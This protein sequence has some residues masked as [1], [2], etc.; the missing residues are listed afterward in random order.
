MAFSHDDYTVAWICALPLEMTAAK[1]ML[2]KL[3]HQLSQPKSDHNA[4]TLGSISGH[5]VVVACLPS[6]VYGTTSAAVVLAHMLLTF[7][8]LRFGLMVGIGGGVP[9]KEA[10]IRLGDVV[11][12]MP[13]ASSGGVIQYDYGKTLRDG[14]FERTGSLNKPPQYLLTAISQMRSKIMGGNTLIEEIASEI[15]QK[16]EKLQEQFSRPDE[17][18]LFQA[19]YDHEGK[20]AD[21]SKCEPDQLVTRTIR[22]GKE[23]VVH[24]GLIA[25]GNQVM[26]SATTRDDVARKLNIL[27]FEMEA[28]GLMDQL[29]CL[30]I[31]GVCD[32]CDSHKH[33]RWQGYAA[34][35]A[36][37]YTRALLG[38]VPLFGS[39]SSDAK[40]PRHWM[41]PFARN[42]RFVG[43]QQEIHYIEN[44]IICATG[45]TKVA[46]HGLGGIGKTQIA[47]ELAYRTR[48]KVPER[49]IFWIP[50]TSYESVQQAYVN[51][52]SALGISDI[53][54]A[55]MKEQVKSHL[56][57][58]R[59]GKWLLIF[60]NADNM[61]M[62]T[63]G[64]ATAPPL[65]NFLP[66]SG[67]G[68]ILFT[69][70]NR[71]L[72][73]KV[74]SPNVLSI[75]DVDQITAMKI[76]EKSLIQEGLLHD[77]YTTTAL[78]EQLGFLPLAISQ[79][80]A[81]MN[82]NKI[83]LSDYLSLL[84]ERETN[85]AE[86]LSEEFEDDGR[87]PE[88]Q[89]P[90]LATWMIS[91]QQIQDL[92]ELAADYLSF[93]A[94]I[95]PRDIP[96]SI[97]PPATSAKKRVDAL[98]LLS[99]YSFIS[100]HACNSS[101]SLHQL[102]H[103]ATRNWMR[104]TEVLVHWVHRATQQLDGIFPDDD[105]NN[106]RLWREYL[107]HAL[108]LI[109][110][111][112]FHDIHYEYVGLSS[113]VGRSLQSDG[114]YNE[115]KVIFFDCL[116]VREKAL[117]PE[118]PD[119]LTSVSNLGSVL[120]QQGKYEEAEAM[121]RRALAGRETIL[122]PEHPD[123]LTSVSHLGSVLEQQS[124]YEEAEAMHRRALAGREIVLGPEHPDTLTSVSLLSSVLER[125]GKYEEA[126]DMHRQAL[127][128][129]KKILGLEHPDTLTSVSHLGFVLKRQGKYEEAEDMHRRA[130][131]GRE[132]VLGPEHPDTLTSVSHLG[133]VLERQGKYGE[134]EAMHRRALAGYETVLGPEHPDTLANFSLL[135]S[136]LKRQ[137]KYEEAEAMHWRDALGSEKV[138]GPE[139]P[140][141]LT[142]V[143]HLGSVLE[144]QGKYE[145]A[146]AIHRRALVGY[147]KA[148]GPEHPDTLASV[149]H[150]GSVLE[151]QGKYE[152]AE[153]IHR[154]A[155]VGYEKALGP[156]HPDT[157]AS[158]SNLGSVLER[159]GK[160]EE[161][162]ALH[163]RDVLGS[164][165]VLGPE[166]PD[167]LTSVSHLGSVLERQGKYEDAEDI[168]R[169][170]LAGYEK[171]LGPK[172]PDTLASVGHLGSVL[173]RQGKYEEAESMHR[174]ALAGRETVLGPEHPDTLTGF[175]HLGFVLEQQGKY[176][177]A[178][179]IYRR[180]LLGY[181][182]ALGSEHPHT[183]TSVSHLGSVL[184]RQGKYE[185]AEAMHRRTLVGYE[186][187]LGPEHP[188]TLACVSHLGSVLE[189]Q[190][191]FEE[192]EAIHRQ[193]LAG[194]EQAL[195]PQNPDTV[196]SIEP[197]TLLADPNK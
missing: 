77:S 4:Y 6:G 78:L 188:D 84:K 124:K 131:A 172:H 125:Q 26:K 127:S 141:T 180:A 21:C 197:T 171:A 74:A 129:R 60:D 194:Y 71:K 99:A 7:P 11:I 110:S 94:C 175:T 109:N 108:Y 196:T 47:L 136:V 42:T 154:R 132:I 52:A 153:A 95:N 195:E 167:T 107:P 53:E 37:T 117:G 159:Q 1:M 144:R 49:S 187:V 121:H 87:Y 104:R 112:E 157:L 128:D 86:L 152:E 25:S 75:P 23:P 191:K 193:A 105:H 123:I 59:A 28:A 19:R 126:E 33:K 63:K 2:D 76:L 186:T 58:D 29:P 16:H 88:T 181:G 56:S 120:E 17:D 179:A 140:D 97:L 65:K 22:E 39:Q 173:E 55:K 34:L 143:S 79:A 145:E 8:S 155:L 40:E 162:E 89:N 166:H 182:K 189:R 119:T 164:E 163:W 168:H 184:E 93:I 170:A 38:V 158:V 176:K 62:W 160:Y 146:E 31:R 10:D 150:L 118:D 9:S 80:S 14:C 133:S 139:H 96:Q 70:R 161:A 190:G 3:H 156:E 151:R 30:V 61:E 18:W 169:R 100:E 32:Y 185:E 81:Y 148:L 57:Q 101:F 130:L 48:E 174:Q 138:L 135:G 35:T 13:T 102:V 46:I 92:D 45:P 116:K 114:R 91:F 122:G 27:C 50:C 165:K 54:P 64:S 177:V 137:G 83:V 192:A 147:E 43:R 178:E 36:A 73:V 72:A 66:R 115:A 142:S 106:Q 134:A 41:V 98:G 103:L 51:I 183:L 68:H 5:N 85:A 90:V 113:R 44:F 15:L 111:E 20:N 67:N 12:S 69:S 149:S 24:Y 82:E